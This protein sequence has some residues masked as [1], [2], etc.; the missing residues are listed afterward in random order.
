MFSGFDATLDT[1]D[2]GLFIF[3][4]KNFMERDS[5]RLKANI[6]LNVSVELRTRVGMFADTEALGQ[7]EIAF[8]VV[9]VVFVFGINRVVELHL[10]LIF[11]VGLNPRLNEIFIM[12]FKTTQTSSYSVYFKA[13][14]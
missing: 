4:V 11:I 9:S 12:F 7:K 13:E 3:L 1:P 2:W 5:R 8:D 6:T 14:P 10:E